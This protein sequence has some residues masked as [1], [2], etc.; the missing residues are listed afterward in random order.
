[1]GVS[2]LGISRLPFGIPRQNDLWVLTPWSNTENTIRG[3]VVTSHKSKPWWVLWIHVYPGS[4]IHQKCFNYTLTNLLF[5]LCKSVWIIE[6]LINLL[7]FHPR[8]LAHPSTPNVLQAMEHAPT[9]PSVI[10]TFGLI[11]ESI[12]ELGG[13]SCKCHLVM[14]LKGWKHGKIQKKKL[15]KEYQSFKRSNFSWKHKKIYSNFT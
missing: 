4:S 6:L 1:M 5:G 3:K 10:F 11:V 9:F 8:A 7:S 2:I 14:H 13:A 15:T 12:K